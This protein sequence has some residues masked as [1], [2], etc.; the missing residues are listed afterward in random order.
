MTENNIFNEELEEDFDILGFIFKYLRYWYWFL[1]TMVLGYVGAYLY[2]KKYTPI[3]KV[4]ATLLIKDEKIKKKG[5]D[6]MDDFSALGSKQMDNEIEVLHS[7]ALI[8][9]VIDALNL[10]VTY[11]HEGRS[12]DRELY[13]DSPIKVIVKELKDYAY[14]NPFYIKYVSE[15]QYQILDTKQD[16]VGKFDFSQLIQSP[17][18]QFRVFRNKAVKP[19]NEPIK[20][21]F[22]SHESLVNSLVGG[23]Q[24]AP[25]SNKTSF[26]SLGMEIALPDKGKAILGK[27]L[28]E[29][30][31]TSLEDKNRESTNTLRFIEERLKLV[32]SELGDVE[33]D[34]E[35]YKRVQGITD[36][37]SEASLFLGKVEENDAKLNELDVQAKVLAGVEGYINNSEAGNLAPATLMVN[38]PVLSGYIT[39]YAQ[40]E[41]ERAKLARS[42]QPGNPLLETVNGQMRNVKQAIRENID[43]QKTNLE[44]SRNNLIRLNNRLESSISTIPRKEREYVGIKR[45]AGIKE[46]L[47]LLLFQ[48][49]EE[50][51]LSYAS[52]VTDSRVVDMP[53]NT[54]GPIKP[55]R[56]N[57]YI[58]AILIGFAIPFALIS[59]KELLTNTVQSKKEIER[60]TGLKVFGEISL[61]SEEQQSEIIDVSS[62][63]F[64]SEQIRMIRSNL[65]YLLPDSKYG[66]AST[67]LIT[68][69][70]SG[71]GKS[72]VTL[73]IASSLALLNKKVVILGL[74]L[75]K[76]KIN[77]YL[78]IVSRKG[79]SNFLIGKA[80]IDEILQ[81]TKIDNVFLIPSGPIPPNPS[82]LISNG[83]INELI[84]ILKH[85]F[86]Y[87]LID[88]PP[89]GL[90]TDAI[91][92]APY[93]DICFYIVR[94]EKTP[95]QFLQLI[96]ELMRKKVFKSINIIFNAVNH[97][98]SAEYGYGYTNRYYG[99]GNGYYGE[100][101]SK[102]GL[103]KKL[104]SKKYS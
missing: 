25:L 95:K 83:R 68:S 71:E 61:K 13:S 96:P 99:Y 50:T 20:V 17:Y 33:Q 93:T 62:R 54:G 51:A 104:F 21:L 78:G 8:G 5:G 89:L 53:Y 49:R 87:I 64:V 73:N 65:Q 92:L 59:I 3:Y 16:V 80:Q 37:S 27:L 103:L 55:D 69:S 48:K 24:I 9:R 26:I 75:R 18:G 23:I 32:T 66:I 2:L 30:A 98:N 11:W 7:R 100:G 38:D 56:K 102:K 14:S 39:Q 15:T 6:L 86:D 47:Y 52:T 19:N 74:D 63:S 40:L 4:N 77:D 82:E 101:A 12:R 46:N 44:V 10:T 36:L 72:F 85:T 42:V 94:H 29:Y 88:T 81:K 28:E 84:E 31:Y 97:K 41:S 91:I 43:N 90:V 22:E 79:V 60:K 45:Q 35:Q 1:L 70:T 67:I 57:I 76:P 34:V 58:V